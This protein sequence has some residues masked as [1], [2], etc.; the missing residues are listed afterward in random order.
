MIVTV[1]VGAL[2]HLF[3]AK[4]N[5]EWSVKIFAD[6]WNGGNAGTAGGVLSFVGTDT[7]VIKTAMIW[8]SAF[9]YALFL[10]RKT[11]IFSSSCNFF[12]AFL[13]LCALEIIPTGILVV[14]AVIF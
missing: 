13:Y 4:T 10:L 2:V 3:S 9:T 7:E 12:S 1:C 5:V 6:L 8:I 11:Q 14:P